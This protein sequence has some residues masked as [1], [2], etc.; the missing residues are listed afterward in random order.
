M[1]RMHHRNPKL[2]GY[3][4]G[5]QE[6]AELTLGVNEIRLPFDQL[7]IKAAA[8]KANGS[9]AGINPAD[10]H[11]THIINVIFFIGM[12]AVGKSGNPHLMSSFNKF[13]FQS[14][15]GCNN[16]VNNRFIP[17]SCNQNSHI[18]LPSVL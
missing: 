14:Q 12:P 10:I 9:G 3:F 13:S 4:P 17:V 11:R 16:T 5:N 8:R 6:A 2:P 7:L 15:N 1:I 18:M